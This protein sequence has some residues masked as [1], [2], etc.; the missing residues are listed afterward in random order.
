MKYL[1]IT[2]LGLIYGVLDIFRPKAMEGAG[3]KTTGQE[4]VTV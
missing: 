1:K 4:G 3:M 2:R